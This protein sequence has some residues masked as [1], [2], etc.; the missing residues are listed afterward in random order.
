MQ[1]LFSPNRTSLLSKRLRNPYDWNLWTKD[2]E[3]E[4]AFRE[5]QK[6][7]KKELEVTK[8]RS[9][10]NNFFNIENAEHLAKVDQS[11]W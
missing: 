1:R 4:E 8:G 3:V 7:Y 2:A 6:K 5:A 10:H 11:S 9:F